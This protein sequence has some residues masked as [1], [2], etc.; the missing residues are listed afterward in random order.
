MTIAFWCVLISGLL[1]FVAVGFAKV[2]RG[3]DNN[4]PREW[5]AK[6]VGLPARAHAA[7]LNSFEAFPLFAAGVLIATF[8]KADPARID[9]LAI[10]FV[11]ARLVYLWC[12]L[13]DRATARS[14]VWFVGVGASIGLYVLAALA[15][16]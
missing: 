10:T 5:L 11:A 6:R 9:A 3:Y 7:H 8:V 16:K 2:T 12:Y 1:P 13:T 15:P 4:N 14:L